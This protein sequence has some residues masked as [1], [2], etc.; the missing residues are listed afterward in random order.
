METTTDNLSWDQLLQIINEGHVVPI[1]G[2]DMLTVRYQDQE[3]RLYPL[4]AKRLAEYLGVSGEG[5]PEGD[6]INAIVCR[7]IQMGKRIEDVYPAL[8]IIMPPDNELS[9]P[10]PLT[11]L[12]EIRPLR[13]FVSTT[14]DSLMERAINEV[15]FGGQSKTQVYSYA[16]NTVEDLSGPI[17]KLDRPVTFHLFGKLSAIPA[18][19]VTQEDTL[20]FL[21]SLQSE[22]RKPN[23]LFD[24]LNRT[25]LLILGCSYKDWLARFFLRMTKR[26]RLIEAR[27][28]T[29]YVADEKISNDDNLVLFLR[30]FSARTKIYEEGG[31][32]DFIDE[33]YQRWIERFPQEEHDSEAKITTSLDK[34]IM[35]P[36]AVFLSYASEDM[37]AA[38]KIKDNLESEG[39]DIFFDKDDIRAG[40]DWEVKIRQNISKCS[41]FIPIISKNTLTEERRFFRIEWNQAIEEALKVAPSQHFIVPVVT[42]NTQPTEEALPAKFRSVQW[43]H[44]P[45]GQTNFEFINRIKLLYRRHQKIVVGFDL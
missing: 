30:H 33:L 8:K 36:G 39:I 15:R 14:F 44:L 45:D 5:L 26:K 35:Q 9:I 13:L 42:D 19:A 37:A 29:D 10:A 25:S 7:Y 23:V 41:L 40:D 43:E 20:E 38:I 6:E 22:T 16:P 1:I 27:G 34:E 31:A 3:I 4:L 18:Y 17:G 24:E 28:N 21:H 11:K 32:L 12:A 2:R